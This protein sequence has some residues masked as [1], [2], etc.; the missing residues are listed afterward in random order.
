MLNLITQY[1][2]F[3]SNHTTTGVVSSVS[4]VGV[5]YLNIDTVELYEGLVEVLRFTILLFGALTAILTFY[6]KFIMKNKDKDNDK[7]DK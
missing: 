4:T 6:S 1:N 5:S 3:L 2:N 7:N